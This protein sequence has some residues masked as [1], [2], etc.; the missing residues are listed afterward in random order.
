MKPSDRDFVMKN[1]HEMMASATCCAEAKEA[2]Q[3]WLDAAGTD[4][5]AKATRTLMEKLAEHV[6]PINELIAA[7]SSPNASEIFGADKASAL[8]AHAKEIKEQG[9][10]YCDCPACGPAK[11]ILE[12]RLQ[13][14]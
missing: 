7:A 9:Q 10:L 3:A 8:L 1:V 5:E 4:Q 14:V 2:G 13:L 6:L 11:A 12:K